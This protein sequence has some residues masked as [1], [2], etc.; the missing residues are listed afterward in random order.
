MER[1][2][3][4]TRQT[5]AEQFTQIG[6]EVEHMRLAVKPTFIASSRTSSSLIASSERAVSAGLR[7]TRM[8]FLNSA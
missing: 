3:V 2:M 4:S 1:A 5:V 8:G 6:V 7:A